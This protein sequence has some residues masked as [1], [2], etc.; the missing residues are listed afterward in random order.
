MLTRQWWKASYPP[1]FVQN[2]EEAKIYPN[3]LFA[4]VVAR[5][6]TLPQCGSLF[7]V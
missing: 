1:R 7:L 4:E 5:D 3:R 2:R 6:L